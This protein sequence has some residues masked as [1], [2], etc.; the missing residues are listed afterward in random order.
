MVPICHSI[1]DVTVT[2]DGD[3]A[4]KTAEN[5]DLM[6]MLKYTVFDSDSED[7]QEEKAKPIFLGT[8]GKTKVVVDNASNAQNGVIL[9]D[10]DEDRIDLLDYDEER[11]VRLSPEI[12][13]R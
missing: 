10:L 11:L 1:K 4:R 5:T 12:R 6:F 8:N 9:H 2:N 7:E 13:T 3:G